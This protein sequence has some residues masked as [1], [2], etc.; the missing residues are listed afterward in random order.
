M[1]IILRTSLFAAALLFGMIVLLEIGRRLG[2]R[3]RETGG[4]AGL[5]AVEGA[6][7]A[8]MGLLIAFTFSGAADRFDKRRQLI[9]DEANAVGTV[10]QYLDVLPAPA[11]PELRDLFRRYVDTRLAVYA[12]L[13]D[14]AAA[15]VE[16]ARA[17][18]LQSAL[19]TKAVAATQAPG[20]ANAITAQAIAALS[21]A[22]DISA[23]RVAALE[24]HPPRELFWLLGVLTLLSALL[25]GFSMGAAQTRSVLHITAFALIMAGTVYVILDLEFPRV[26]L[27]RIDEA[28]RFIQEARQ[29][30]R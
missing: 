1:N 6:V 8:L 14:Y 18:E 20:A 15:K 2:R 21:T 29:S 28:D 7:F 4:E 23:A 5:G 16:I 9:L 11:Q 12:R 27:I 26:G 3:R 19:W 22:F 17:N 25:A 24:T 13:P 10:W 30:M